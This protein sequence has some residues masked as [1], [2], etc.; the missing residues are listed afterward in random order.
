MNFLINDTPR[1]GENFAGT[2]RPELF[3]TTLKKADPNWHYRS[4]AIQYKSNKLKYRNDEFDT[5]DWNN[6]I[7]VFG[8]SMVFGI[9]VANDETISHYL[10]EH[11]GIATVNMGIG[12]SSNF[13][14]WHNVLQ[15]IDAGYKPKA[16]VNVYT[17][18]DRLLY[19]GNDI[20]CTLGGWTSD[21]GNSENEKRLYQSW[22][23]HDKHLIGYAKLL[24]QTI[25]LLCKDIPYVE[26]SY[27]QHSA[28]SLLIPR[29]FKSDLGRDMKHPGPE[30]NKKTALTII[31]WLNT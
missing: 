21:S 2:D 8:C 18:L 15:L 9:G 1:V 17:T 20:T 6:S 11:T 27:F 22:T 4:K 24:Q 31:D 28:E 29:L 25:Q 12:G 14:T 26:C 10:Q 16:I 23:L 19:F 5:I 13:H 30:T 3:E 7:V